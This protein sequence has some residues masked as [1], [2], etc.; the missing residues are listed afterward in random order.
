MLNAPPTMSMPHNLTSTSSSSTALVPSEKEDEI[1]LSLSD[2]DMLLCD[3]GED[4]FSDAGASG[5]G[6]AD[7]DRHANGRSRRLLSLEQ[8]KVLYKILDK[9]SR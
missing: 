1:S 4:G 3:D 8:S 7:G 6:E 9:V 5:G 2:E